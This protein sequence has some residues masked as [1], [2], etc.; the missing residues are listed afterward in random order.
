M[1][2]EVTDV[3]VICLVELRTVHDFAACMCLVRK[4]NK[5]KPKK[6][7]IKLEFA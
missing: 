4:A 3:L 2:C 7:E 6:N 5:A 1:K